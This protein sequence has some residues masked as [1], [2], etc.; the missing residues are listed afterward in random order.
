MP[1]RL[2]QL[3]NCQSQPEVSGG[4][5]RVLRSGVAPSRVLPRVGT[6]PTRVASRRSRRIVAAVDKLPELLG[7]RGASVWNFHV[8]FYADVTSRFSALSAQET[9]PRPNR[10]GMRYKL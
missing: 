4:L 5:A 7:A 9:R 6:A 10:R 1:L 3:L 8:N 2:S